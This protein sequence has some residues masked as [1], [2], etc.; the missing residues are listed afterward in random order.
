MVVT[1][2]TSQH[3]S[4]TLKR[5]ILLQVVSHKLRQFEQQ[6]CDTKAQIQ[7]HQFLLKFVLSHES[8]FPAALPSNRQGMHPIIS[9]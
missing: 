8:G 9:T 4:E 6:A 5:W 1:A 7:N 2:S 3:F